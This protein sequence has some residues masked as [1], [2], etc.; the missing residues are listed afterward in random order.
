V[1]GHLRPNEVLP[2]TGPDVGAKIFFGHVVKLTSLRYQCFKR[3]IECVCCGIEGTVMLLE[4]PS[5]GG[6]ICRPHFNLYAKRE[7]KLVQMTK[8]HIHPKS[9]KGPDRIDNM[10]TMCCHCN[11]LKGNKL[12]KLKRL[13]E[14]RDGVQTVYTVS[15]PSGFALDFFATSE[16]GLTEIVTQFITSEYG[17]EEGSY[18][19]SISRLCGEIFVE[20]FG[21]VLMFIINTIRRI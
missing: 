9:E 4:M 8:D 17:W 12:G 18:S 16:E 11:E 19:I 20:H 13:R 1:L 7:G 14:I 21:E 6:K 2:F 3:S 5:N 10:Q 15:T